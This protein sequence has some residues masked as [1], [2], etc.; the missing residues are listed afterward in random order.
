MQ[1]GND[2]IEE[3]KR[4]LDIVEVVGQYV[5]LKKS[6][7]SFKGLCPFHTEKTPSF[8]V[9]PEGQRWH[10]FGACNAGGDIFSFLMRA[11]NLT[12]GEALKQLA[13][14]AGVE[15]APGSEAQKEAGQRR[16]HL[17]EVNRA[18]CL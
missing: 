11:E 5:A 7:R 18:G 17:L 15:L 6:G 12:F 1:A 9:F 4:R 14:R 13:D 3:I 16:R 10:C 8:Y 2:P